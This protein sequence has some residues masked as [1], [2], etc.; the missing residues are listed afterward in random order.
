MAR[1]DLEALLGA[2]KLVLI[3]ADPGWGTTNAQL[4]TNSDF[5]TYFKNT[6]SCPGTGSQILSSSQLQAC[7]VLTSVHTPILANHSFA[8]NSFASWTST[9]T[10]GCTVG[11]V[12]SVP[13]PAE[14]SDGGSAGFTS[15]NTGCAVSG[16]ST[17]P[18]L[19]QTVSVSGTPTSQTFSFYYNFSAHTAPGDPGC[20]PQANGTASNL[21]LIVNGTTVSTTV[22]PTN[23]G[24]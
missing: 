20:G 19:T 24:A 22:S 7:L 16:T 13:A 10:S 3:G 2:G 21:K 11:S 8:S 15:G 12:G 6:G 9:N 1:G 4:A 18:T 5:T 17:T 14:D 23:D